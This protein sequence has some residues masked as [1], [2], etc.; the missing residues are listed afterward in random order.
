MLSLLL[1][2]LPS[3][4]HPPSYLEGLKILNHLIHAR[5]IFSLSLSKI[6][7]RLEPWQNLIAFAAFPT[8]L[9][10]AY[11][12]HRTFFFFPFSLFLIFLM[13]S[14][15][16][17]GVVINGNKRYLKRML[18]KALLFNDRKRKGKHCWPILNRGKHS[19]RL[20]R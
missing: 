19:Y 10:F 20:S 5:T 7:L 6:I 4:W 9:T 1:S 11:K 12:C 8:G 16:S 2:S 15:S 14:F 13:G 18:V 3:L 17:N